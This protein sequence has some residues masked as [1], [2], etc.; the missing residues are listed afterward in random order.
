MAQS[1][2]SGLRSGPAR[3]RESLAPRV[4]ELNTKLFKGD[5]KEKWAVVRASHPTLQEGGRGMKKAE[6]GVPE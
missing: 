1:L 4:L 2:A 5:L 6:Q 3:E